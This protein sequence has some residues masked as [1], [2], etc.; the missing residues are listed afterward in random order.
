MTPIFF[1]NCLHLMSEKTHMPAN[2]R[3]VTF[4]AGD[5]GSWLITSNKPYIG[6]SWPSAKCLEVV[7]EESPNS[8]AI[9]S[10]KGVTSNERYL[11]RADKAT[12]VAKQAPLGRPTADRAAL[13]P[14]R[15][16]SAWW[17]LTQDERLA[18]FDES[19]NAIGLKYLPAIARRLHHCR[20]MDAQQPFDFLTWFDY[21]A[22]DTAAF[23][24]LVA[25]L[26][27][28]REWKFVDWE[29]DIRLRR[30]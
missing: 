16:N 10:L 22:A 9:W 19:H 26:R 30:P 1:R 3:L 23:E 18:I 7:T 5:T 2:S 27:Q 15:K 24:D 25:A 13:I 28:T 12:L 21:S 11:A 20:D 4:R 17:A 29:I 6:A 8:P 14:I